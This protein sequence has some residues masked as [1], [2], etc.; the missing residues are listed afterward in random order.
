MNSP[1]KNHVLVDLETLG[2]TTGSAILSIGATAF[3][4][5]EG[6]HDT[7][8]RVI[9]LHDSQ[10]TGF[11][12]DADTLLWWNEQ[13]AKARHAVFQSE[14]PTPVTKALTDFRL[15]YAGRDVCTIWGNSPAFDLSILEAAFRRFHFAV[16][17]KYFQE[18]CHRTALDFYARAGLD[19]KAL[20]DEALRKLILSLD[21]D[22]I[23]HHALHDALLETHIILLGHGRIFFDAGIP[24]HGSLPSNSD[25]TTP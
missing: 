1:H 12:I 19:T 5:E 25:P 14:N 6:I 7:F 23:K 11:T 22:P 10:Q 17:W 4:F 8:Y 13:S 16:P 20:R 3:T 9:D 18:R 15:W 2:T 21:E 24:G